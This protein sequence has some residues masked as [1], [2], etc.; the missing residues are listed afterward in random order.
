MKKVLLL[1]LFC[2]LFPF[3]GYSETETMPGSGSHCIACGYKYGPC[4]KCNAEKCLVCYAGYTADLTSCPEGYTLNKVN[5][6]GMCVPNSCPSGYT[7]GKED[8]SNEELSIYDYTYSTNGTDGLGR[9]CGKCVEKS[10]PTGYTRVY[11]S[12]NPCNPPSSYTRSDQG[13]NI[14]CM[15]C[16]TPTCGTYPNCCSGQWKF[17]NTCLDCDPNALTCSGSTMTCKS[18]YVLKGGYV[19]AKCDSSCETC[20]DVGPVYCS[21]CPSGKRLSGGMCI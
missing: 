12:D 17:S 1:L 5:N 18:G 20:Y 15:K 4:S 2:C 8:C 9:I 10:C 7:A 13:P 16:S 14:K 21:S 11:T 19:C 3:T 6:C